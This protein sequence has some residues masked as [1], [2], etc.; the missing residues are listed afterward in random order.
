MAGEGMFDR[1]DA[2]EAV[3]Q[4]LGTALDRNRVTRAVGEQDRDGLCLEG[5]EGLL[6]SRPLDPSSAVG[7]RTGVVDVGLDL[8][9]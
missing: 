7:G 9:K 6:P 4:L 2:L 1:I 3:G 8:R 5:L